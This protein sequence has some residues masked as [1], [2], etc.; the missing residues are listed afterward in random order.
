[1]STPN[2]TEDPRVAKQCRIDETPAAPHERSGLRSQLRGMSYAQG[3]QALSPRGLRT[4]SMAGPART[5]DGDLSESLG[6]TTSWLDGLGEGAEI[7]LKAAR[8]SLPGLGTTIGALAAPLTYTARVLDPDAVN[9]D[10]AGSKHVNGALTVAADMAYSMIPGAGLADVIAQGEIFDKP[11]QGI[12]DG[13]N[14]TI[15]L[16]AGKTG[17]AF[18]GAEKVEEN[19]ANGKYGVPL[20]Y[21]SLG[22]HAALDGAMGRGPARTENGAITVDHPHAAG[23]LMRYMFGTG[24]PEQ[25]AASKRRLFQNDDARV[26]NETARARANKEGK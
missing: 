7:A 12:I 9:A 21:L 8:K 5:G 18:R 19:A 23:D 26:A 3:I 13:S 25:Q 14:A 11:T 20:K 6:N 16:A 24:T 2:Y 4:T 17:A 10:Y 1:M 22:T 15:D